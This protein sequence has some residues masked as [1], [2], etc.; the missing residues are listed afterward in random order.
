[1][2]GICALRNNNNN[3]RRRCLLVQRLFLLCRALLLP[4]C[5]HGVLLVLQAA[6]VNWAAVDEFL[7]L[8]GV[9]IEDNVVITAGS[10]FNLTDATGLPKTAA[11]IEAAMAEGRDAAAAAAGKPVLN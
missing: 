4:L 3:T 9:R 7:D 8:G 1:M 6:G 2:D 11:D 5:P 10:H